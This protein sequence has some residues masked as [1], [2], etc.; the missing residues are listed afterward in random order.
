MGEGRQGKGHLFEIPLC[1][2]HIFRTCREN[3]SNNT[4]SVRPAPSQSVALA[5][6]LNKNPKSP[7]VRPSVRGAKR[8]E[9]TAASETKKKECEWWQLP[10]M[11][12]TGTDSLAGKSREGRVR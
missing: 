12:C 3:S 2:S 1:A 7:S 8:R 11:I 9:T 10:S 6:P 4:I 5:A